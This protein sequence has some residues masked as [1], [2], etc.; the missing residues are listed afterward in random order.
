MIFVQPVSQSQQLFLNDLRS[1]PRYGPQ[2]ILW[3]GG[4]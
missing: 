1:E 4:A 3:G 2:E